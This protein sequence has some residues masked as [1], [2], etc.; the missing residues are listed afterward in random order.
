[1]RHVEKKVI[2]TKENLLAVIVEL[3]HAIGTNHNKPLIIETKFALGQ[4]SKVFH[5]NQL[6]AIVYP[7]GV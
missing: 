4:H 7:Q 5:H 2:L 3:R 6:V 1:M